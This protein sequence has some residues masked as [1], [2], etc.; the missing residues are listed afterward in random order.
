MRRLLGL[1]AGLSLTTPASAEWLEAQS[2]HFIIYSEGK[3]E[4]LRQFATE[5]ERFDATMR[6]LRKMEPRQDSPNNRLTVFLVADDDDV[7]SYHGART[8]DVAGF[9]E[10]RAG[11]S[12]AF[13]PRSSVGVLTS[14]LVLLHEYSHHFMFR[15]FAAAYPAWFTEGFAEFSASARFNADGS[16]DI[17]M[18]ARHRSFELA[19]MRKV[20][21]RAMIEGKAPNMAVYSVGWL[22]THYLTFS[23]AR[24]G[25]LDAY[26]RAV[27]GGKSSVAAAE[28]VFGDL[29]K[30]NADLDA[31]LKE[32]RMNYMRLSTEKLNI[33]SIEVR[34]LSPGAGQMMPIFMRSRRGVDKAGA[35]KLLPKARK[36]AAYHPTDP[37]VQLALAEAEIDCDNLAEADVAAERVL[38]VDPNSVR[39]MVFRGR[40]ALERAKASGKPAEA[41]WKAVRRWFVRANR[42]EPGAP[43]PLL[44]FYRSYVEE[45]GTPPDNAFDGLRSAVLLAPED[46][47]LRMTV[48]VQLLG[49]GSKDEARV[50]LAPLAYDPHGGDVAKVAGAIVAA[51][52]RGDDVQALVKLANE[53]PTE[54]S[55]SGGASED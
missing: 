34:A 37:F 53:A 52:D 17:G 11:E 2:A 40:V 38:S 16:V 44:W 28:Q 6:V 9:Y 18:P 54:K 48:A 35:E 21:V 10:G 55:G 1:L 12:Y 43:E 49:K 22:L 5:L 41:D 50:L 51:I 15:N 46:M 23:P 32:K 27:N 19:L 33:G 26:L 30:L 25:Q 20:P 31:Y 39:A 13:V 29:D 24:K 8:S 47:P 3:P 45:G 4:Q 42:L 14:K 36:I 7:R